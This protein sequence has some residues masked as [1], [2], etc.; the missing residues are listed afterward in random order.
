MH[1]FSFFDTNNILFLFH[2]KHRTLTTIGADSQTA[3]TRSA[4]LLPFINDVVAQYLSHSNFEARK[5]A[6]LTCCRLLLLGDSTT[7]ATKSVD[8]DDDFNKTGTTG[9]KRGEKEEEKASGYGKVGQH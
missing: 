9:R 7:D 5:E 3:T 6:A 4:L 2:F 8:K 1:E